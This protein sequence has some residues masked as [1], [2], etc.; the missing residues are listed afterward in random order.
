MLA[1]RKRNWTAL[2][3][4]SGTLPKCR[5]LLA[6]QEAFDEWVKESYESHQPPWLM[7]LLHGFQHNW[8]GKA[9]DL[10]REKAKKLLLGIP[11]WFV[12]TDPTLH[13]SKA[14]GLSDDEMEQ[15]R[16]S[17]DRQVRDLG[18]ATYMGRINGV[19]MV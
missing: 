3:V 7:W 9:F 17:A 5:A 4:I 2:T 6:S 14:L 18:W 10:I 12:K 16:K 13:W 8:A 1:T 11:L 19:E 15:I